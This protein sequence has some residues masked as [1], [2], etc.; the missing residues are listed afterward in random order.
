MSG[1]QNLSNT[2]ITMCYNESLTGTW[3]IIV[4]IYSVVRGMGGIVYNTFAKKKKKSHP[5]IGSVL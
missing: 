1:C 5:E 4:S 3:G 2:F